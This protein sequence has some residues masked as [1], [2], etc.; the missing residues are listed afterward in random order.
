MK[1]Y[2]VYIKVAAILFIIA[3]IL[4]G[5]YFGRDFLIPVCLGGLLAILL[6]PLIKRFEKWGINRAISIIIGIIIIL[7]ILGGLVFLISSQVMVFA[8]DIPELKKSVGTKLTDLQQFIE[9]YTNMSPEKQI[10]WAKQRLS[11]TLENSGSFISG[12]VMGT[13]NA[14]AVMALLPIY[15]FFFQFYKQKFK[16]FM[17]KVSADDQ[18]YKIQNML[19]QIKEVVQ[20]YLSGVLIVIAIL[21]VLNSI[22]L[23]AWGIKYAIFLGVLAAILNILPYIGILIGNI[24]AATVAFLTTDSLMYPIGVLA[25]FAVIQFLENNFLTP[26]IVGSKVSINPLATIMVLIIGGQL[27]GVVGMILFI[28]FL[29]ILKVIF[30][31]IEGMK[32]YG[33]LLGTEEVSNIHGIKPD[34]MQRVK[35]I[36][37]GKKNTDQKKNS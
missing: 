8:N 30:D 24:I 25:S 22:A 10:G 3:S 11:T 28:P 18:H 29:G 17:F 32:P 14:L 7:I 37:S 13:T 33:Y 4:A 9:N 27:W 5:L 15:I 16:Q 26:Q 19:D 31:N 1:T 12:V 23:T 21:A 34:P 36:F 2:P 20:S 35:D 6:N